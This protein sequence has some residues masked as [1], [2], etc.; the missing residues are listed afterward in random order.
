MRRGHERRHGGLCAIPSSVP[1]LRP[2]AKP[3]TYQELTSKL[4][5]TLNG[6]G[7]IYQ[8]DISALAKGN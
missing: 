7:N 2:L 6:L 4:R 3:L 1:S 8:V 5:S